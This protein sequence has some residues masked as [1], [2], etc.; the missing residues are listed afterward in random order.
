MTNL[1]IFYF[2]GKCL[3]IDEQPG[4]REEIIQ[5]I[6]DDDID[7]AHFVNLCSNHLILPVIYLKFK[8]HKLIEH[9]PEELAEF[10]NE[11]YDLNLA[12]NEKILL[13]INDILKLLNAN[14]IYPTFLKGTGNL[15]DGLYS[16]KGERMIGDI[17][18]LV[19]DKDYL[20]AAK[21][22]EDDGYVKD[23]HFWG[24]PFV[25]LHYPPLFKAGDPAIIELHRLIVPNQYGKRFDPHLVDRNQ[26]CFNNDSIFFVLT[27]Q[28][29]AILNF[30]HS[31]LSHQGHINGIISLRDIYDLYMISKR[32]VLST[33][34]QTIQFKSK[35]ATYFVFAGIALNLPN[36][37]YPHETIQSNFFKIKHSLIHSS[38]GFYIFH[39]AIVFFAQKIVGQLLKSLFYREVRRFNFYRLSKIQWYIDYFKSF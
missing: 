16:D 22:L 39:R 15:L 24:D 1:E 29:N 9:L 4:F 20:K 28:H 34:V 7:W 21:I 33:V 12:R 18:F 17:D 25:P 2:V 26:R 8:A 19:P 38:P 14:D 35:A 5:K 32:I 27:D 13:Q 10:L 36:R 37:F 6:S 30:I 31:Q 3:S 11:I 23:S